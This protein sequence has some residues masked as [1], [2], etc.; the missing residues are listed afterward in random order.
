MAS[1]IPG[2]ALKNAGREYPAI[3]QGAGYYQEAYVA[4]YYCSAFMQRGMDRDGG[5]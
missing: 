2:L 4:A 5:G 3:S 1:A